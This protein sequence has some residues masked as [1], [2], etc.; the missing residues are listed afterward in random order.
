VAGGPG[1]PPRVRTTDGTGEV[2]V[3]TYQAFTSTELLGQLALERILA[4]LS[5]R[6]YPAG[7]EPVGTQ[8]ESTA[9]G[10][11]KSA[12]SRRFV[13]ATNLPWP[14]CSPPT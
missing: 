11:S 8:V 5:T 4:K 14:N 6:R 7:L 2:A 1:P 13:A 9:S 3:P 12:I 10:T